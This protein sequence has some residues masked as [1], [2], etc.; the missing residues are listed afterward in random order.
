VG[1]FCELRP[2]NIKAFA[3]LPVC[4]FPDPIDRRHFG[5]LAGQKDF[6]ADFLRAIGIIAHFD[7]VIDADQLAT[8]TRIVGTLHLQTVK[9]VSI[10]RCA[11]GQEEFGIDLQHLGA[12]VV[13]R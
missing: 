9:A 10:E 12:D 3:L 13:R 8:R 7:Q 4:T 2:L 1:C 6:D 11:E 5:I